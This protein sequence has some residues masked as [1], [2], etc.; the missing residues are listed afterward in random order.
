M[1]VRLLFQTS[2]NIVKGGIQ[3]AFNSSVK[4]KTFKINSCDNF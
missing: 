4:M 2:L 1:L 3:I